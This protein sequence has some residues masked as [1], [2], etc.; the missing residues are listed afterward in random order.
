MFSGCIFGLLFTP[1]AKSKTKGKAH[2][3]QYPCWICFRCSC[4]NFRGNSKQ[5]LLKCDLCR[6]V[7]NWMCYRCGHLNNGNQ[8]F[9]NCKKCD[10]SRDWTCFKCLFINHGD[11][12]ACCDCRTSKCYVMVLYCLIFFNLECFVYVLYFLLF[13]QSVLVIHQHHLR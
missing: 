8:V 9:E 13:E 5:K 4:L 7:K 2:V 6:T 11:F 3:K 10:R 12:E 1:T